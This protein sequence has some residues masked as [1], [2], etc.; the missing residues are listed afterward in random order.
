M[1]ENGELLREFHPERIALQAE[2]QKPTATTGD[3]SN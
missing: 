1:S 2:T 3:S